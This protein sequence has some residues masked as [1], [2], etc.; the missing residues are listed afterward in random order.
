M[1]IYWGYNRNHP[2][3]GSPI[4][5]NPTW[6]ST[7]TAHPM[8]SAAFFSTVSAWISSATHHNT[9][10]N[11][12]SKASGQN[13]RLQVVFQMS[14]ESSSFEDCLGS[15]HAPDFGW[16][17]HQTAR[18]QGC[19]AT[20]RIG[21]FGWSHHPNAGLGGRVAKSHGSGAGWRWGPK[22]NFANWKARIPLKG[23]YCTSRIVNCLAKSPFASPDWNANPESGCEYCLANS[24]HSNS[25]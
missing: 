7:W 5:G 15:S 11:Q 14:L 16:T 1:L 6:T 21:G 19:L 8:K 10:Q 9:V 12:F 2:F 17:L 24:L 25:D 18:T 13:H 22:S 20:A 4:Y 3:W 23:S